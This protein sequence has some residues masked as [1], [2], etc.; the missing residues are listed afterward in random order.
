MT[1]SK[2]EHRHCCDVPND[3]TEMQQMTMARMEAKAWTRVETEPTQGTGKRSTNVLIHSARWFLNAAPALLCPYI[4]LTIK[5]F[6][7]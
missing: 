2:E 7:P 5:A 6:L 4:A 3:N 1:H